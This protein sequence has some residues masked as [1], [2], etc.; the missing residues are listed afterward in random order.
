MKKTQGS[1]SR[2]ETRRLELVDPFGISR[3]TATEKFNTFV[4]IDEG[5]GEAAPSNYYGESWETVEAV[6]PLLLK[7]IEEDPFALDRS[8]SNLHQRFGMNRAAKAAVD[9]AGES[10]RELRVAEVS[11]LDMKIEDGAVTAYRAKVKVSFR[12][13][14]GGG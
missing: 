2:F 4:E 6:L 14:G 9:R 7:V 12:Y 13:E 5:I 10:L 8:V 11:E 1:H 3:E